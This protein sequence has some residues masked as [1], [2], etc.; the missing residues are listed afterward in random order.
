[1]SE[2]KK[3]E[4]I[5]KDRA[6]FFGG[7]GGGLSENCLWGRSHD[8]ILQRD[9]HVQRPWC[10][11]ELGVPGITGRPSGWRSSARERGAAGGVRVDRARSWR[12]TFAGHG[13]ELG[14]FFFLSVIES[15]NFLSWIKKLSCREVM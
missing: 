12:A 9:Q 7:V 4:E 13:K 5:R 3:N 1:M 8:K 11:K 15:N 10:G 6:S 2:T 14:F